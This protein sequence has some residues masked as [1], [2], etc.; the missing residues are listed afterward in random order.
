MNYI[1][2][3]K[4][5]LNYSEAV[6]LQNELKSKLTHKNVNKIPEI[7]AGV[8]ISFPFKDVGLCVIVILDKHL[9]VVDYI[10]HTDRIDFPYIPGLLSFREGPLFLKTLKKLKAEPEMFFFDG[11][12]IAHPRGLGLAAHMGLFMQK[13]TIGIAKSR[14]FGTF[15]EPD[16]SKGNWTALVGKKNEVIGAVLRTRTNTKPVFVSPGHLTD[17][18]SSVRITLAFTNTFKIPEPTR[19]AHIITQKLKANLDDRKL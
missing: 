4:W 3:H 18:I 12:G 11:Q 2:L 8:D 17:V 1:E 15:V 7:V 9:N 19:R 14:L 6:A 16:K 5:N 13:P 10:Y